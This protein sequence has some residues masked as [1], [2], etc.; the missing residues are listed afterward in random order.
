MA[1]V[2]QKKRRTIRTH[3]VC[4]FLVKCLSHLTESA[5]PELRAY[6]VAMHHAKL[7][8]EKGDVGG[9]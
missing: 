3:L 4:G 7:E 9:E 5:F 6:A 8:N 1:S 2:L